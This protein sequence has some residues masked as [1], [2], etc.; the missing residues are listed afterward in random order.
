M[1][2]TRMGEPRGPMAPILMGVDVTAYIRVAIPSGLDKYS[3]EKQKSQEESREKCIF[4]NSLDNS[5]DVCYTFRME[6]TFLGRKTLT[7]TGLKE[8]W[9][10]Y[11]KQRWVGEFYDAVL[12]VC[13]TKGGNDLCD[14]GKWK[15]PAGYPLVAGWAVRSSDGQVFRV[16]YD[17]RTKTFYARPKKM[18]NSVKVA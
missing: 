11:G 3:T 4:F 10:H 12:H 6:K 2:T 16:G 18:K 15:I 9:S 1:N 17:R 13:T 14:A 5:A 7:G 8:L